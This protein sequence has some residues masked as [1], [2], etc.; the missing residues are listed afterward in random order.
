MLGLDFYLTHGYYAL[1]LSLREPFV[2]CWGVGNS[3]FLFRQAARILDDDSILRKPY[4]YR[5]EK[6]GWDAEGVWSSIYPWIAS[7]TSF[8]GSLIVIFLVGVAFGAAWLDTLQG[9]NPFAVAMFSEFVI[10]L[11]Y[12][13]ANNQVLQSGEGLIGFFG[14]LVAWLWTR[15][16]DPATRLVGGQ[17]A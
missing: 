12:F 5:I 8:P 14:T 10:M 13:P 7:D 4:P 15:D 3:Y 9:S 1:S 2:P 16:G 6:Y 11:L 17:T